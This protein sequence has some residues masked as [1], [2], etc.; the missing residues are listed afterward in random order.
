MV[1]KE[2]KWRGFLNAQTMPVER[3][4]RKPIEMRFSFAPPKHSL[5]KIKSGGSYRLCCP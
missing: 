3:K 1:S 2:K 4:K 5:H